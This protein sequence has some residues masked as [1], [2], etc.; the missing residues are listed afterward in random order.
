MGNSIVLIHAGI[1]VLF[2]LYLLLRLIISVFGVNDPEYQT[3]MRRRFRIPDY[4]FIGLLLI[5]GLYPIFILGQLE[6]YHLL[7]IV[8]LAILLWSSRIAQM[9]FVL[10]SLLGIA[11]VILAGYSSFTDSPKF[12]KAESSFEKDYPEV[13]ALSGLEKGKVIFNTICAECHGEDGRK[14]LF[15]AADLTQSTLS[16]IQKVDMVANGSPLTVMRSFSNDLTDEEINAV[17]LYIEEYF[18][19]E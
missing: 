1:G 7:K 9:N 2:V 10:A 5:T 11:L 14:G 8:L 15:Q 3:I 13:S 4:A 16:T 6:L 17:V 18:A 12:P 19:E